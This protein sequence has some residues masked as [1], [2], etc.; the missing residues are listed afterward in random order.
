MMSWNSSLIVIFKKMFMWF[1]AWNI[2]IY[3]ISSW[4]QFLTAAM[5]V[6]IYTVK[7]FQACTSLMIY[8]IAFNLTNAWLRDVLNLFSSTLHHCFTSWWWAMRSA[9]MTLSSSWVHHCSAF[10]WKHVFRFWHIFAESQVAAATLNWLMKM[11][12]DW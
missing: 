4:S 8:L 12:T 7:L 2:W 11:I 1:Q 3:S 9:W 10:S 6:V 5:I